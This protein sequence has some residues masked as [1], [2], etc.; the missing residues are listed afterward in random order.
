[1]VVV[2]RNSSPGPVTVFVL[3]YLWTPLPTLYFLGAK[4]LRPDT[5]EKLSTWK[6]AAK[7]YAVRDDSSGT[8]RDKITVFFSAFN[9]TKIVSHLF[10]G[11]LVASAYEVGS[12]VAFD[13]LMQQLLDWA[14][15]Q[16][17]DQLQSMDIDQV[18]EMFKRGFRP[19]MERTP[20]ASALM[21]NT[22][23]LIGYRHATVEQYGERI[24]L[25]TASVFDRV[26]GV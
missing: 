17:L 15:Q 26:W 25:E 12:Q 20:I 21:L 24:K 11:H 4:V 22:L 6:A 10:F 1:M 5:S 13:S 23:S 7:I 14:F 3:A 8:N 18:I 2:V 9:W 16:S 19:S